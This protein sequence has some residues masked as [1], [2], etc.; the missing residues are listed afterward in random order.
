M[1]EQEGTVTAFVSL[2]SNLAS[3][4]GPPESTILAALTRLTRLSPIPPVV[5]SLYLTEPIDCPP[6]TPGF[7]NAVAALKVPADL[8][9]Q[10]LLTA[11]LELE[12][13]FGRQRS[14][15]QNQPRALDLDLITYGN[16][17]VNEKHLSLPHP[18][19][20]QRRFVL[21]PIAEID[22]KLVLPGQS[23]N[24]TQLLGQL[25]SSQAPLQKICV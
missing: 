7:V 2:G 1:V 13:E 23:K 4:Y 17:I 24:V 20:G 6:G 18:R 22:G 19:A 21:E 5:S 15:S 11:L 10:A 16:Q 25:D 3:K 14:S 8:S 12:T 9:A